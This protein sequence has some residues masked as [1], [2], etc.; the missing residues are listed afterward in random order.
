M[1]EQQTTM[2][3]FGG[4]CTSVP[5][6]R[7][8]E[9][10]WPRDHGDHAGGD[11]REAAVDHE[12]EFL[13]GMAL[14]NMLPGPIATQLGIYLGYD[15]AGWRGGIVAGLSF[16]LPAFV[17]LMLLTLAYSAYGTVQLARNAFYGLGPVVLGIFFVAVYR[18]GKAGVRTR[19][20]VAIAIASAALLTFAPIGIAGVLLLAG[21][22]GVAVFHSRKWG[23]LA[24]A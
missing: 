6:A 10:R 11:P 9:L 8:A 20:H 16:M 14:V 22:I 19:T 23:R 17:I 4:S 13:E 24:S 15:R 7:R 5:E 3:R 18:L 2:G 12:G 1:A 21:C